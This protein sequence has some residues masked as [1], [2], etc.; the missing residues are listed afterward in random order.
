MMNKILIFIPSYNRFEQ[1]Y[2]TLMLYKDYKIDVLVF[3]QG[4]SDK[5]VEKLKNLS[6]KF[7]IINY[8]N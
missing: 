5:N 8:Y 2:Q 4:Y 6:A 3:S 1:L 7:K